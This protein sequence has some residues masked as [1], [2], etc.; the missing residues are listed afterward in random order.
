MNLARRGAEPKD[1]HWI[2]ACTFED[3]GE[4]LTFDRHFRHVE[5]LVCRLLRLAVEPDLHAVKRPAPAAGRL[6]QG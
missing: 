5:G 2:A 6:P 3:G 4:L 1:E